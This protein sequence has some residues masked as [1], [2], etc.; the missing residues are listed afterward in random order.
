MKPFAYAT[1]LTPASARELVADGGRYIGGGIDLLGELKDYISEPKVLVN[2]KALPGLSRIEP[3]EKTWTIGANV[4]V[5]ELED[6]DGLKQTFRGLHQAAA[7][8]GSRQIRNVAT[9]GGNLAQHSRCWYYRHR[10]VHCLKK[11]GDTCYARNG[12]NK[13]H[14]LFTGNPC[15]SPVVSNLAVALAVLDATVIVQRGDKAQRMTVAEFYARAWD[16]PTAH[17][18]LDRADLILQVEVPVQQRRSCYLQVSEK[19][20]FDWALVSCAAAGRVEG[21]KISQARVVLGA[22]SNVPHQVPAAHKLLEGKVLDEPLADKAAEVILEQAK[23]R[24]EN[25][26]KI[27]L[28]RALIRRALM[29]LKT[30]P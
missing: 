17:N 8:V 23:A 29:Q 9:V 6:H 21:D 27:P 30:L 1:A 20:Q 2:V 19:A 5:A 18:S 12:E 26:Y 25:G 22:I 3:G 11:G 15:I 28:A 7:E 14:S 16:N 10:D 4:T 24:S 13:Y